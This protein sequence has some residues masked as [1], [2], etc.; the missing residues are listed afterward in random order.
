MSELTLIIGNKNY[1]SWSLRP[2]IALKQA[3]IPFTERMIL[4]FDENWD[5]EI[6]KVSPTKKVP[7][8]IDGDITICETL[9][10]LEYAHELY[11]E[12]EL[13]PTDQRARAVAR[14]V[15]S[16]MHAGFGALRNHMSMNIRKDHTGR[17]MGP[18]VAEDISRVSKIWNDCRKNYGQNGDFLFGKFGNADAMFAPVVSRFKTFG[19]ELDA[20]SQ[21]YCD[22][23]LNTQAYLEWQ[24]DAL[25]ETW[26]IESDE[27][28]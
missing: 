22:V 28:D 6:S 8:L 25:K 14:S 19:V 13:W 26:I 21:A 23:V 16:E 3:D 9:A 2:W 10:I 4:L 18:G 24:S 11:P 12:K 15:S 20:V 5:A 1:S 17:G 27:I 7:V